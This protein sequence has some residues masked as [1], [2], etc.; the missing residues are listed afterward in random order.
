MGPGQRASNRN[1]TVNPTAAMNFGST[2]HASLVVSAHLHG[3]RDGTIGVQADRPGVRTGGP[4]ST[5]SSMSRHQRLVKPVVRPFALVSGEPPWMADSQM[6]PVSHSLRSVQAR[7][8][9]TQ[10]GC[11]RYSPKFVSVGRGQSLREP[12]LDLLQVL[13]MRLPALG[14]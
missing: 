12:C 10:F 6:S 5:V 1:S 11:E 7:P 2:F 4:G 9:R 8:A 13:G 14:Q 3:D